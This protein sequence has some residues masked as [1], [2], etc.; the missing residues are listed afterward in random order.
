MEIVPAERPGS[1]YV[2]MDDMPQSHV[3]LEDPTRLVIDYVRHFGDLVDAMPPGPLRV[4]H[5][6]GAGLTLPRYVHATRPGSRQIVLEPVAAITELVRRDLPLPRR[7]GIS[8][9]PVDGRSGLEA[10]TRADLV[11]LDAFAAAETP[12]ELVTAEALARMLEIASTVAINLVDRAP[13]AFV[14]RVI[15]SLPEPCLV[16]DEAVLKGRRAGNLVVAA[17]A[18]AP[19]IGNSVPGSTYRRVSGDALRDRFGGGVPITDA[20][21]GWAPLSESPG[22]TPRTSP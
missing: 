13:F 2:R 22:Q 7:S 9:R 3:D 17:G 1:Y 14:R 8:V 10:V 15:A 12:A 16:A 21:I 19:G 18:S 5:I 11:V 4:V 20:E 6:G